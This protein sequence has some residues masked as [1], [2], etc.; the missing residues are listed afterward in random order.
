VAL[1]VK[2]LFDEP[3]G[4]LCA[5]LALGLFQLAPAHHPLGAIDQ[6]PVHHG[7]GQRRDAQPLVQAVHLVETV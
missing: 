7:D 1:I 4:G 2:Q 6:P 3:E 5:S